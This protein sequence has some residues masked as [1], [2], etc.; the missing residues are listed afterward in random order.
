MILCQAMGVEEIRH[1]ALDALKSPVRLLG[2]T[3]TSDPPGFA[4]IARIAGDECLGQLCFFSGK[5][6]I[7]RVFSCFALLRL[8]PSR[9][10]F[11]AHLSPRLVGVGVLNFRLAH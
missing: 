11:V 7:F 9:L 1:L 3:V 6:P 8:V 2:I 4:Y 10:L 5:A